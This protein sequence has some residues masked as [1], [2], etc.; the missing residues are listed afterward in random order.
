MRASIQR[1]TEE[2]DAARAVRRGLHGVIA[3]VQAERDALAASIQ[4]V[5]DLCDA[6]DA[7]VTDHFGGDGAMVNA[8]KVRAAL[9]SVAGESPVPAKGVSD[10]EA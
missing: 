6:A 8:A 4:R 3:D 10:G 9:D 5:R 1:V 7:Y 2:R